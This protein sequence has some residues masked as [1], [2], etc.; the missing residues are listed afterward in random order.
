MTNFLP[1]R[2]ANSGNHSSNQTKATINPN[3]CHGVSP[4]HSRIYLEYP[5]QKYRK[6]Q[7]FKSSNIIKFLDK[8]AMTLS[9]NQAINS[10]ISQ[11]HVFQRVWNSINT[12]PI[13][14]IDMEMNV[15]F[16]DWISQDILVS[17]IKDCYKRKV[18]LHDLRLFKTL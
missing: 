16:R 11:T 3:F 6:R 8:V 15:I 12:C 9:P 18:E 2:I 17:Q 4:V 10:L 14:Q 5:S 13:L 7:K 1:E